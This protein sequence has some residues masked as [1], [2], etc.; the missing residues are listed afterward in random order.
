MV[1]CNSLAIE[2]LN[3]KSLHFGIDYS[4]LQFA[5][6]DCQVNRL[7]DRGMWTNSVTLVFTLFNS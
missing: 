4:T 7:D 1:R 5:M 3:T 2:L 6:A